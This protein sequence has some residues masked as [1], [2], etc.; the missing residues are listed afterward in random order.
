[1]GL[2]VVWLAAW[3]GFVSGIRVSGIQT[4]CLEVLL[5]LVVMEGSV[6]MAGGPGSKKSISV[7]ISGENESFLALLNS[8]TVA[9]LA[10]VLSSVGSGCVGVVCWR[11]EALGGKGGALESNSGDTGSVLGGIESVLFL[12]VAE[13]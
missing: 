7:S 12:W 11:I 9:V 8:T 4:V 2:S 10:L 13:G 1:M 5:G 6:S 3:A